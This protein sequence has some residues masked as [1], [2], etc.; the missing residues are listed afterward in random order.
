MKIY[1]IGLAICLPLLLSAQLALNNNGAIIKVRLGTNLRVNNG[2]IENKNSGNIEN[3]GNI[4]LD[5]T[6]RQ[7]TGA[8]YNGG[9]S[10]WLWFEG[11]S[12]QS[13]VGDAALDLSG[14]RVDNGNRLILGNH[15][16]VNREVDLMMNGTIELGNFNLNIASGGTISNYDANNY[17]ITNSIG[18]LQQEVTTTNVL[19]PVGNSSYNPAILSNTGTLDKLQVRVVDQV[20]EEGTTGA[21]KTANVVNRTWMISE[22]TLGGSDVTMTL[23]WAASDELAFDRTN[24]G[25]AHHLSGTNWDFPAYGG[26]SSAGVNWT[27]TRSG[28]TSFSPFVVVDLNTDLPVEMLYFDAERIN[29]DQVQLDWAT[30]TELNNKGFD[31]ERML[32]NETV[33]EKVGYVEGQGTTVMTTTYQLMDDNSHTGVSYYRLKQND[34]DGTISYSNI[35]AVDGRRLNPFRSSV[36]PNPIT[37]VLK[38]RFEELPIGV[39]SA[40]FRIIDV[41]GQVLKSFTSGIQTN[42]LIRIKDLDYLVPATYILSVE[43]DN[44]VVFLEKFIKQEN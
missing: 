6:F 14:L 33:F 7:I 28:F 12:N 23:Q 5:E 30:A 10:S 35:R 2:S 31:I 11:A 3:N 26:A 24:S 13:A 21:V 8:S 15:V 25:I 39:S 17:V 16:N 18:Y 34:F 36:F 1:L 32:D 37:E 29:S 42:Q 41:N 9:S 19:F 22:E 4:Y 38:V 43:L 27:Q 44:G 20:L 40:K